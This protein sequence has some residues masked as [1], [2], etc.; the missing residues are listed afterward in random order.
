MTID[1]FYASLEERI[2]TDPKLLANY[3]DARN[4]LLFLAVFDHSVPFKYG[5]MLRDQM[6]GPA[7]IYLL[8]GHRTSLLYT[9]L[10]NHV[11]P[12]KSFPIMPFDYIETE[13]LAFF[14]K[15]FYGGGPSMKEAVLNVVTLPFRLIASLVDRLTK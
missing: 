7:A 6:G 9:A 4:T 5:Q 11:P 12:L 10:P 15:S 1:E 14:R 13:S 8:A 3:M 2:K